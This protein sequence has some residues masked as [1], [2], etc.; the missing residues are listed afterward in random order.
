MGQPPLFVRAGE[1]PA[2]PY[3]TGWKAGG[4]NTFFGGAGLR[5]RHASP[6]VKGF[7]IL[8]PQIIR[9]ADEGLLPRLYPKAQGAGKNFAGEIFLW[10]G[11][12]SRF[13]KAIVAPWL[14]KII[15]D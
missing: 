15:L 2:R 6:R 3:D 10:T 5:A 4:T 7:I 12:N 1:P 13:L 9:K 14:G 11:Y 8:S